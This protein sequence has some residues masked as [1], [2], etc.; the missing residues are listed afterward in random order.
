MSSF[1]SQPLRWPPNPRGQVFLLRA[2]EEIGRA[3][4]VGWPRLTEAASTQPRIV[5]TII[6]DMVEACRAGRLLAVARDIDSGQ[7]TPIKPDWWHS[8]Q[9]REWFEFGRMNPSDAFGPRP[10]EWN[11]DEANHQIFIERVGLDE[12]L[13]RAAP[14]SARPTPPVG[15]FAAG[16]LASDARSDIAALRAGASGRAGTR[17]EK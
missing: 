5:E 17:Y 9:A 16:D 10:P 11:R 2:V 15:S 3:C 6:R 13:R 4:Y 12:F 7:Q 1:W 14:T 8:L